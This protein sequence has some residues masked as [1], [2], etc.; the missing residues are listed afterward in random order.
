MV[1]ETPVLEVLSPVLRHLA[2]N[3]LDSKAEFDARHSDADQLELGPTHRALFIQ[4]K[5]LAR[6][7]ADEHIMS[8]LRPAHKLGLHFLEYYGQDADLAVLFK[9]LRY[10]ND[11]LRSDGITTLQR[12]DRLCGQLVLN[13]RSLVPIVCG[14]TLSEN[15][16]G[17]ATI[18]HIYIG[19]ETHQGFEWAH[20]IWSL[21]QGFM[22]PHPEEQQPLF[23]QALVK[24]RRPDTT[25]AE[26]LSNKVGVDSERKRIQM[27]RDRERDADT[28]SMGDGA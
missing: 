19:L 26:D 27:S 17:L 11:A 5:T 28:K 7:R 9:K 18:D 22:V 4:K 12:S 14:Y 24:I 23:P 2:Q 8:V 6:C 21:D 13:G 10:W 1:T 16:A 25:V 20:R 15:M 3:W